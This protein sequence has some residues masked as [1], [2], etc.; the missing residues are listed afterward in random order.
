MAAC[1][2]GRR[3]T[4][5]TGLTGRAGAR[6]CGRLAGGTRRELAFQIAE[7][8][9]VLGKGVSLKDEVV[10]GGLGTWWTASHGA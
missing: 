9:R 2:G 4:E 8:F 5:L 10:V 3:N 1:E 7:Q 6:W